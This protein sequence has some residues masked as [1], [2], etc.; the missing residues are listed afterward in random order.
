MFWKKEKSKTDLLVE[1]L[2]EGKQDPLKR[3][4][5]YQLLWESD[6]YVTGRVEGE[7]LLLSFFDI[8]GR[9]TLPLFSSMELMERVIP[10]GQPYVVLEG[11]H[12]FPSVP[13]D[14]TAIL[15]P[16]TNVGKEFLPDEIEAL[17]TGVL[18]QDLQPQPLSAGQKVAIGQP[19]E[20]PEALVQA[21]SAYFKHSGSVEKAYLAQVYLPDQ[22]EPPH[23][24]VG[25]ELKAGS[26]PFLSALPELDQVVRAAI[27]E[28]ALVDFFEIRQDQPNGVASYMVEETKPFYMWETK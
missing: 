17:C 4:A 28:E 18:F 23:P 1:L 6:L 14:V 5:F 7:E 26:A 11:Q 24:V 9:K 12:L 13:A 2:V 19:A 25:I 15:N 8:E 3:P 27:G 22:D 16:A 10:E 20:Y 21:L